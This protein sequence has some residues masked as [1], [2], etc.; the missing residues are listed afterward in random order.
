MY[1]YRSQ[2]WSQRPRRRLDR[3]AEGDCPCLVGLLPK[4]GPHSGIGALCN[5]APEGTMTAPEPPYEWSSE[6]QHVMLLRNRGDNEVG[7][8]SFNGRF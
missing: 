1:G 5:P 2:P 8:T 4:A 6:R 7:E 3:L